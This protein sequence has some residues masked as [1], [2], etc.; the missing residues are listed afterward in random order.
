LEATVSGLLSL[1]A[2][3]GVQNMRANRCAA[4]LLLLALT[5]AQA[6]GITV[7][8]DLTKAENAGNADW[9]IGSSPNWT[10][11]YSE[12]GAA[13]RGLGY[14][15]STL[16]G[17]TITAS[18][19]TNVN[20]LV[21]PE[22]Q[23][24]FNSSERTVL[25]NFVQ[26][27][28][29]LFLIADHDGSDRNNNGWDSRRVYNE[30][31]LTATNFGINFDANSLYADPT[32][33]IE[34]PVTAITNG[35]SQVGMY[36]G[37]S[38]TPSGSAATHIWLRNTAEE[39]LVTNTYGSGRVAAYG[40]SSPFDDGTGNSG[41]DLYDGWTDY[42]NAQMGINTVQWLAQQITNPLVLSSPIIVPSQPSTN[43][44]IEIRINVQT[45]QALSFI[46]L[47]WKISGGFNPVSMTLLSGNVYKG[48]I[49]AQSAA[50]TVQYYIQ[51]RTT[52]NFMAYYPANAPATVAS[53]T[54]TSTANE[55]EVLPLSEPCVYPNP[56]N[57]AKQQ[58]TFEAVPLTSIKIYNSKGALVRTMNI[59]DTPIS[60]DGRDRQNRLCAPGV[61]YIRFSGRSK[62]QIK[63]L[64]ILR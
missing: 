28:G 26:N 1:E 39:G 29:G 17:S 11:A 62:T 7:A 60:W 46:Y 30:S 8:F 5:I 2:K 64:L 14:S 51:A 43:Q 18:M 21:L 12:F 41:N 13:L 42:N 3:T 55:E 38:I 6:A 45:T 48:I 52:S 31:L 22:P 36:A 20:V 19:L 24:P 37:C 15:T 57:P 9:V 23:N 27:G 53:F 58:I 32:A 34:N 54:I 4:I 59:A 40:D 25:L 10:G 50:A 35:L 33:L 49:P 44:A 63:P 56:V 61:Y 16:S 47:Y